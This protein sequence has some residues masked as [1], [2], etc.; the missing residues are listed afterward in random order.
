MPTETVLRAFEEWIEV[1][2]RAGATAVAHLAPGLSAAE[3]D[4]LEARRG[5]HLTEDARA[6]WGKHNGA[7]SQDADGAITFHHLNIAFCFMDL[8]SAI[9]YGAQVLDVRRMSGLAETLDGE[10]APPPRTRWIAL[11]R[12]QDP[13]VLDVSD[14]GVRDTPVVSTS[15]DARISTFPRFALTEHINAWIEATRTGYF[16]L[17]DDGLWGTSFDPAVEIPPPLRWWPPDWP[18]PRRRVGTT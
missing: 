7:V 10:D 6:L 11:T 15:L 1:S 5:F 14:P 8:D 17:T 2:V 3:L 12:G 18:D 4:Q 9:D 13:H 16:A